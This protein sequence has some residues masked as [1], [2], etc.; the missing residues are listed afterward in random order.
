MRQ[1]EQRL[2]QK[3]LNSGIQP[4][5]FAIPLRNMKAESAT[6]REENLPLMAEHQ[7]L[8]LAYDKLIAAQTIEWEGQSITT[9][10]L[11]PLVQDAPREVKERAWRQASRRVLQDREA[12]NANW[13][14]LMAVRGQIARN[15]GLR[16]YREFAWQERLRFDYTP[17]DCESFHAAIEEVVVPAVKRLVYE[18]RRQQYGYDSLRPWD[19]SV[20]VMRTTELHGDPLGRPPLKPY[21]TIEELAG[22]GS[23]VFHRVDGVFGDYFDSL[24]RDDLLDLPNRVNKG[25]GA[26]CMTYPALGKPFVFMNAVGIHDN[27]QTLFHECGHAFHSIEASRQPYFQLRPGQFTIPM[28]FNEVASMAMELLASPYLTRDQG[29]F[30][31]DPRD[32]ARARVEHLQSIL[33]FWPYMAVVD[34]F[35][36]WVYTHHQPASDPT[37]CDA[38]W[39]EL[40][41]RFIQGVDWSG[42]D[43]EKVTGWQ[44]KLH[45]HRYP[46]Y[47][48]EYGLAQLG[49]VLIW[50]N[51]LRDQAG[52]VAAYRRALA[53]GNSVSLPELYAAAGA[54]LAFDAG[55]LREAVELIEQQIEVLET[56]LQ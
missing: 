14:K 19:V 51:A 17:Q 36:H 35:Q 5:G 45:I 39:G 30:Y 44:R 11:V 53:L 21:Q 38:A 52:A 48:I 22:I 29:G 1:A 23:S 3:L 15:A 33:I 24:R 47:Y 27:V 37:N 10:A 56:T 31:A 13:V 43:D 6:F 4:D 12:I 41:D 32:A 26:F 50:R 8:G 49:A 16:D 20:D 28:E 54:R 9:T 42:L 7:K 46:F 40:W 25:P 2:K 18:P 34:A 55:T